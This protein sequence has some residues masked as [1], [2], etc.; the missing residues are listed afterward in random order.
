MNGLGVGSDSWTPNHSKCEQNGS[1]FQPVG[2]GLRA[3]ETCCGA[4]V[5]TSGLGGLRSQVE[6]L[7]RSGL[8]VVGPD[9]LNETLHSGLVLRPCVDLVLAEFP[10][11]SWH[12]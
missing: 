4:I 7:F 11:G 2:E 5:V 3:F 8:I 1:D 12:C 6:K 10:A 9:L